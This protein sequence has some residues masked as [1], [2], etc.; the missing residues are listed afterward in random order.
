MVSAIMAKWGRIDTLVN[1]AGILADAQLKKMTEEQ[2]QIFQTMVNTYYERF[3]KIVMEGRPKMTEATLREVADG[4]ILTPDQAQSAGL[5]DGVMYP[6][7]VY[8]RA[9]K[10]AGLEDAGVVSYE[11]P[12]NQRGNVLA[13]GAGSEPQAGLG[14]GG[15]GDFNLINFDLG[16]IGEQVSGVRFMYL[17]TP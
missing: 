5:I 14:T 3:L 1:N 12:Y 6:D 8:E 16:A 17:W 15:S 2:Q 11:Y 13:Q 4:R 10:L 9:K 7:E